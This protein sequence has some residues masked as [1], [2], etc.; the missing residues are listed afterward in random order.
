[1]ALIRKIPQ[2][3]SE[4]ISLKFKDG[5]SYIEVITRK[6]SL[7]IWDIRNG[8]LIKDQKDIQPEKSKLPTNE[9][10]L[11]LLLQGHRSAI[12]SV[13]Y[14]NTGKMLL[15][16]SKNDQSVRLWEFPEIKIS[17]YIKS[18]SSMAAVFSPD[19][20]IIAVGCDDNSIKLWDVSSGEKIGLLDGHNNKVSSLAFS[21]DGEILVSGSYDKSICLW[22]IRRRRMVRQL[23][24]HND[25]VRSIACSPKGNVFASGSWDETICLWN[26]DSQEIISML[27]RHKNR[28]ISVVF[29]P[30]G[31][32]LASGSRDK[33][34]RI[35]NAKTGE[36]LHVLYGHTD[37]VKAVDFSPDGKII[38][39]GSADNTVRIW[40]TD[41]GEHITTLKGH[42]GRVNTI[43]FEPNGKYLLVAGEAGRLQFWNYKNGR[44]LL[45]SYCFDPDSW[46]NLLPDRR[47]DASEKGINY[48]G[49]VE[50]NELRY[51]K[52]TESEIRAHFYTRDAGLKALSSV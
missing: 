51:H 40:R 30:Q 37:S 48:L 9:E 13:N 29:S 22:E 50:E 8:S 28:V 17:R 34:V 47:F 3:D 20:S 26:L 2:H 31:K 23:C 16:I 5:N 45:Y 19:E 36:Q 14:S 21:A 1:M 35:W 12:E 15:S 11:L 32:L 6:K 27:K 46:L 38:A 41:N 10:E 42:L 44:P 52:A 39:S 24:F 18:G 7:Y 33:T 49:Y 25:W 43:K 4:I